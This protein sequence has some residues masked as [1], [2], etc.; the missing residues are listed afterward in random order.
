MVY[1][2]ILALSFL[3][4]RKL[5]QKLIDSIHLPVYPESEVK[6]YNLYNLALS[7]QDKDFINFAYTFVYLNHTTNSFPS[8]RE[9]ILSFS[10][11]ILVL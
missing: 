5:I 9:G 11:T 1:Q 6:L 2:P 3:M 7:L 8:Q 4:Q 10:Y